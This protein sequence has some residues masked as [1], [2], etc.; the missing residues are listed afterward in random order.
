MLFYMFYNSFIIPDITLLILCKVILIPG[1]W[2]NKY[3]IKYKK[4][5]HLFFQE[6]PE[7]PEGS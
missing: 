7:E 4:Y 3:K 1:A 6:D 2:D 5:D